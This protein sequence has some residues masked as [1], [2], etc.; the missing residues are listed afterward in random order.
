[1]V[2]AFA[3]DD[4]WRIACRM[5]DLDVDWRAGTRNDM[6]IDG[7]SIYLTF[8]E[9]IVPALWITRRLVYLRSALSAWTRVEDVQL[10]YLSRS[11]K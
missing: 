3:E 5:T 1:M 9:M 7:L 6:T 4:A 2:E 8:S 10:V 11:L